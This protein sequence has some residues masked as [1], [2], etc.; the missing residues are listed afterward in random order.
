MISASFAL[1]IAQSSAPPI[2]TV[3]RRLAN[4]DRFSVEIRSTVR[5]GSVTETAQVRVDQAGA[6]ANLRWREPANRTMDRT[7]R[8]F[9]LRGTRLIGW[10]RLLNERIERGVPATGSPFFRYTSA[11]RALPEAVRAILNPIDT[12]TLFDPFQNVKGWNRTVRNGQTFFRKDFGGSAKEVVEFGFDR[13]NRPVLV[14][15]SGADQVLSWQYTWGTPRLSN[16]PSGTVLVPEFLSLPPLGRFAG[17]SETVVRSWLRTQRHFTGTVVTRP[18]T[19]LANQTVGENGPISWRWANGTLLIVDRR[20]RRA[21]R[22]RATRDAV[23]SLLVKTANHGVGNL[24]RDVLG[25]IGPLR[26]YFGVG[27]VTRVVGSMRLNNRPVT[28]VEV[29]DGDDRHVFQV[30][31]PRRL[32]LSVSTEVRRGPRVLSRSELTFRYENGGTALAIPPGFNV[33]ALPSP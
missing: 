31:A 30:D 16:L 14:R 25:G 3:K 6:D 20:N 17:D 24:A 10:D 27:S 29:T 19:V 5:R 33:R 7:D 26:S 28:L 21:W 32:A 22:G 23:R 12:A 18:V 1:L 4:L 15:I 2:A 8:E 11:L 9:I 13:V